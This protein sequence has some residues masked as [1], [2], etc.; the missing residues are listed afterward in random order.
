[1]SNARLDPSWLTSKF[2]QIDK[3]IASH[4]TDIASAST[5][6]AAVS[7]DAQKAL[8]GLVRAAVVNTAISASS[9]FPNIGT[10]TIQLIDFFNPAVLES[11][12]IPAYT[13]NT[14]GHSAA[15]VVFVVLI[16]DAYFVIK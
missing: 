16:K 12:V 13:Y 9:G 11:A 2:Q 14:G 15:A 3:D 6:L 7:T 1:M 10:G 5:N 4:G 8:T